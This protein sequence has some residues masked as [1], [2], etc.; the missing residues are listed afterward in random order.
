MDQKTITIE[1]LDLQQICISYSGEFINPCYNSYSLDNSD[2]SFD[3]IVVVRSEN[4]PLNCLLSIT[5]GGMYFDF[6]KQRYYI[7]AIVFASLICFNLLLC[8]LTSL[9]TIFFFAMIGIIMILSS[10]NIKDK[11]VASV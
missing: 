3:I 5:Y 6:P 1:N 11:N 4:D 10:I 8:I 9:I 2:W 7:T